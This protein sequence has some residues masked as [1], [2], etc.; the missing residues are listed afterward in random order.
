MNFLRKIWENIKIELGNIINILK[1]PGDLCN[2]FWQA[3]NA[4]LIKDFAFIV[5]LLLFNFVPY[6]YLFASY[7]QYEFIAG[8]IFKPLADIILI[9]MAIDLLPSKLQIWAKILLLSLNGILALMEL[10]VIGKYYTF[11]TAGIISVIIGTNLDETLEFIKMYFS[12]QYILVVAIL[13]ALV[14][15][16]YYLGNKIKRKQLSKWIIFFMP[17]FFLYSLAYTLIPGHNITE[18]LTFVRLGAPIGQ[19]VEDAI[20][21]HDIYS[22]MNNEV[23]LTQNNSDIPNVVFILGEATT[24]DHMHL[25]GYDLPTTPKL[26]EMAKDGQIY[27][28]K[29]VISPH[30][31]TIGSLREVFTFHNYEA[32]GKWY[33]YNNII[34]IANAAGYTTYWLSNQETSGQWANVALAYANRSTYKEFTGIRQSYEKTFRP[35]GEIL[36]LLYKAMDNNNSKNFYV[37]HLMGAHG[38]YKS[39]Y[40]PDF[41]KFTASDEH[42]NSAQK[43][44]YRAEYDNAILYNDT[45]VW[46]I[47]QAFKDKN[48][49]VIYMPDHGE[50]IYDVGSSKGHSDDN[51]TRT[52]LEIPFIIYTTEQFRQKYPELNARIASSVNRPYMTDDMIH[53]L[54]D[55]MNIQ[56]ADYQPTRSLINPDFNAE[57]KRMFLDKDY[58]TDMKAK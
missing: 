7:N 8:G 29:D 37:L 13:I 30:A 58:D 12:W 28:F 53:T 20:E 16:I 39:R 43:N 19:A 6:T 15:G 51:A 42:K 57:R 23:T 41:A 11:M 1:K 40:T 4:V 14:Y 31:Y 17:F 34:D 18:C 44:Q 27:V 10:F 32:E 55:I 22:N 56:T 35:D 9:A 33:K 50:E 21:F 2:S 36:P 45:I 26:D 24:R 54:L 38:D 3:V 48:A 46:Q 52:M 25:Y 5:L 47:M 49:I